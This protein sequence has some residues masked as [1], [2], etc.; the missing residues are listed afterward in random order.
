MAVFD[1]MRKEKL[2][3]YPHTIEW[4]GRVPVAAKADAEVIK[5][6][7]GE[8]LKAECSHFLECIENSSVPKTDGREGLEVLKILQASQGSLNNAGK[9]MNF[10]GSVPTIDKKYFAHET[11]HIDPGTEIGSG[12]KIWHFSHILKG[13]RVGEN[14]KIGQNVVI[15]PSAVVGNNCKIQNNVS[16]YTGV[17]LEDDVFCGPSCVFTNVFNP[18]SAVPRMDE[19]RGTVVKKGASIGAN[20]TIICGNTIGESAFIGAGSV[21]TKD[22]PSHALV[23]GNPARIAGWMC[24]CGVKIVFNKDAGKC[25]SCGAEYVKKGDK[26]VV[27][28]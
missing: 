5:I 16:V 11:A 19:I 14:C 28:V 10:S 17:V 22:I 13:S 26:V 1:D 21:V 12:T 25:S 18:R 23:M 24:S 3:I 20:A 2:L 15:G 27:R 4:K 7:E 8:P 9:V 6:E